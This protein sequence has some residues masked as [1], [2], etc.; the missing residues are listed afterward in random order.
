MPVVASLERSSEGAEGGAR[1]GSA[2]VAMGR[3]APGRSG[4]ADWP[5][6]GLVDR[7]ASPRWPIRPDYPAAARRRGDQSTVIVEAWVDRAGKVA[8]STVLASG[9]ELFDRSALRAVDR[10]AF[11]PASLRGE[12]V[13]SRVA[14]RIHFA[15]R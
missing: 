8:A 4:R 3:L 13:D 6:P 7:P 10:A 2:A 1:S 14:L 11:R 5:G 12:A 9:G 15:L